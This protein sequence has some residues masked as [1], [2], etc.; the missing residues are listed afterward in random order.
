MKKNYLTK[1]AVKI[2]LSGAFILSP[3]ALTGCSK[4]ENSQTGGEPTTEVEPTPEGKPEVKE[5]TPLEKEISEIE[6]FQVVNKV[7][8]NKDLEPFNKMQGYYYNVSRNGKDARQIIEYIAPDEQGLAKLEQFGEDYELINMVIVP[9]Y[10]AYSEYSEEWLKLYPTYM[11][12]T[13]SLYYVFVDE[14]YKYISDEEL[15]KTFENPKNMQGYQL[16]L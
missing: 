11:N 16:T 2:M 3:L 7:Y 12:E 13:N 8:D 15:N 14:S 5:L 10:F 4:Q 1:K 6:D 9:C